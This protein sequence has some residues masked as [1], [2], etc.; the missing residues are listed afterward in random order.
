MKRRERGNVTIEQSVIAV[1]VAHSS[2]GCLWAFVLCTSIV[3][4]CADPVGYRHT[5]WRYRH[6]HLGYPLA[7]Q[8]NEE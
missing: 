6:T 8:Y 7:M 3:G 5:I 1:G 2:I 4:L